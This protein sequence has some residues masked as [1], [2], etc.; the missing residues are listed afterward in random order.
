MTK[1]LRPL[2]LG[3]LALIAAAAPLRADPPAEE[4]WY[5]VD[6]R[7]DTPLP[8]GQGQGTNQATAFF[9]PAVTAQGGDTA[10]PGQPAR[11]PYQ[12]AYPLFGLVRKPDVA[13]EALFEKTQT[14]FKI[15]VAFVAAPD[16]KINFTVYVKDPA[17]AALV[18]EGKKE[19]QL[20]GRAG[21]PAATYAAST[22]GQAAVARKVAE[23]LTAK[24]LKELIPTKYPPALTATQHAAVRE[25]P[26][27]TPT[28]ADPALAAAVDKLFPKAGRDGKVEN[29][30]VLRLLSGADAAGADAQRLQG[31][32][33]QLLDEAARADNSQDDP[34]VVNALRSDPAFMRAM[35]GQVGQP[36]QAVTSA[37]T[38]AGVSQADLLEYYC[39]K[40]RTARGIDGSTSFRQAQ[41]LAT[42]GSIASRDAD[43]AFVRDGSAWD[44]PLPSAQTKCD[45]YMRRGSGTDRRTVNLTNEQNTDPNAN[46]G[47]NNTNTNT[48]DNQD[49][50]NNRIGQHEPPPEKKEKTNPLKNEIFAGKTAI[51]LGLIGF[52][53]GGPIGAL[54]LGAAGAGI[55]YWM[56]K[57]K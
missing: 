8:G 28:R 37:M 2:A 22:E 10:I 53:F 56:S 25:A 30:F 18:V 55:G 19:F 32:R 40:I 6:I 24:T 34:Q 27:A 4:L 49:P 14:P 9:N 23:V 3:A 52:I 43:P 26:A 21:T 5:G 51:W 47:G 1:T 48:N 29:F 13:G 17:A 45:E 31:L 42:N 20:P 46:G 38:S 33:Q 44:R 41:S 15:L 11:W 54:A 39:P 57:Y 36:D 50:A 12:G 16:D 35:A 7:L